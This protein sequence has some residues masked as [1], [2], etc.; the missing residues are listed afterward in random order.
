MIYFRSFFKGMQVGTQKIMGS[1]QWELSVGKGMVTR[2]GQAQFTV[3]HIK[4][5]GKT[6]IVLC[7]QCA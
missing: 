4:V 1:T 7:A 6:V 5:S 3:D 2:A